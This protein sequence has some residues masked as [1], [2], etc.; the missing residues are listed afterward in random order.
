MET[1]GI[2]SDELY[3]R[4][5]VGRGM[6]LMLRDKI[7]GFPHIGAV[8]LIGADGGLINSSQAWPTPPLNFAGQDYFEALKASP[9]L[10]SMLG[11]P[12]QDRQTGVWTISFAR[13]F[14]G[15]NGEF[16]GLVVGTVASQ[17]FEE[18]YATLARGT[19]E[20][21]ALFRHDG[22]MLARYPHIDSSIGKSFVRNLPDRKTPRSG[23]R[24]AGQ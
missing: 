11:E 5:M 13:K 15:S 4:A 10:D 2:V 6:H 22:V 12:T 19:D 24:V 18:S 7:S 9:R 1:V 23:G 17:Y 14:R 20:S 16:L 21:I 3:A 8:M